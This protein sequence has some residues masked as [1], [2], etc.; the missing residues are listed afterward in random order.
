[1][2]Q[3]TINIDEPLTIDDYEARDF[4]QINLEQYI[5]DNLAISLKSNDKYTDDEVVSVNLPQ[6]ASFPKLVAIDANKLNSNT[7]ARV[8]GLLQRLHIIKDFVAN[9]KSG[10]VEYPIYEVHENVLKAFNL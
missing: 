10:M 3:S 7:V 2:T 5:T 1:M 4:H 6:L 9:A 8:V